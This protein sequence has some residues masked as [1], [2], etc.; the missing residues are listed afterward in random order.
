MQLSSAIAAS[1]ISDVGIEPAMEG[2]HRMPT[3]MQLNHYSNT[4]VFIVS[5][6]TVLLFLF[7]RCQ[8]A[9]QGT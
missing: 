1:L 6:A 4:P 8:Y 3:Q 9:H 2:S 7:Q 5:F